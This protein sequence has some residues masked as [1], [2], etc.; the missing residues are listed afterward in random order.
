MHLDSG[1]TSSAIEAKP[2]AES[3]AQ[4]RG[5]PSVPSSAVPLQTKQE[6]QKMQTLQKQN[7]IDMQIKVHK[8]CYFMFSHFF[9]NS[10]IL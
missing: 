3:G 10:L 9:F 7:E 2:S 8:L 6:Y 4:L 1:P 5:P